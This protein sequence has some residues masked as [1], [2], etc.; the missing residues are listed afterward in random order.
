VKQQQTNKREYIGVCVAGWAGWLAWGV[1]YRPPPAPSLPNQ[2]SQAKPSNA[3][4]KWN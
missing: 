1:G 3:H 4:T 2:E